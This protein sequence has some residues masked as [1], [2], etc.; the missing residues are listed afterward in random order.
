MPAQVTIVGGGFT[1]AATAVQLVR[2]AASHVE[3]TI[4]EPRAEVG[5]G[6]AYSTPDPDHRLNG[7]LDN[8]LLDP[9]VPDHL[10]RWCERNAVLERDPA[11]RADNG[12]IFL[13]RGDFGA[14]LADT[15]REHAANANGCVIR[16]VRTQASGLTLTAAGAKVRCLDGAVIDADRVVIATGNGMPRAPSLLAD[17]L[18]SHP[19]FIDDA[20]DARRLAALP[21]TARVLVAGSGLTALD[22]ISTLL[23]LGHAGPIVSLSRHGRRPRAHRIRA[24][25]VPVAAV[26]AR[27]EGEVP[28]FLSGV[29]ARPSALALSR[30]A[31]AH[32]RASTGAGAEWHGPFDD[33][34]NVLWQVWTRL[35]L[36][37]KRRALRHLRP[38][39]DIH[40]FR[41]PPQNDRIVREAERQGR[42]AF[43]RGHLLHAAVRG[44]NQ[45]R[46]EW[47]DEART[48]VV[49][50]DFDAV[51]SCT[52]LD[53]ACGARENPF[54]ES[55]LCDGAIRADA[56]GVG[57]EVD[58]RCRPIGRDGEPRPRLRMV[59]PPTAGAFADPLGVIFIA[60][61]I[62]RMMRGL[63][64]EIGAGG[65]P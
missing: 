16:H 48:G 58:A 20:F 60:A 11:A 44:D 4:I 30:A 17:A 3:V 65:R 8:H 29:M 42:V 32:I 39:Y 22:A 55:L 13:R 41:A 51:V 57:F 50:Q 54:L 61:Q 35:P 46:I 53:P 49:I 40:R 10:R 23:R 5:P 43:R 14:Y 52:G 1:G 6:L 27:I 31:R 18:A 45:A 62:R 12:A 21:R 26:L 47:R 63:L 9:G 7:A 56:S 34:R 36:E 37:E 19:G 15:V 24:S 38:W 25:D 2:A 28:A 64:E 33:V 59:G